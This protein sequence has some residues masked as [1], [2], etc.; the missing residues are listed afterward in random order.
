MGGEGTQGAEGGDREE[1]WESKGERE[2]RGIPVLLFP[3]FEHW[4]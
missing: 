2:G 4:W 1:K 3:H